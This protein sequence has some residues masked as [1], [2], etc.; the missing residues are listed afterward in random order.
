M[1]AKARIMI[2]GG[3]FAGLS[4]ARTLKTDYDVRLM[5]PGPYFEF[6]PN[7]HELVS[8]RKSALALR[9]PLSRLIGDL[10]HRFVRGEATKIDCEECKVITKNGRSYRYDVLIVAIGGVDNTFNIPGADKFGHRFK[11]VSDCDRIGKHLKNLVE[12]RRQASAVIVGGGLEGVEALGE[13]LRAYRS[14]LNLKL[15]VIDPGQRLL[16]SAPVNIDREIKNRCQPF[17]ISFEHNCTVENISAKSVHLTNGNKIN[18]DLTIWTGGVTGSPLLFDSGLSRKP[19]GWGKV[20]DR[21]LSTRCDNVFIAGDSADSNERFSRQ[22]YHATDMGKIAAHNAMRL[23]EGKSLLNFRPSAKPT[24]I[25]FGD[26]DGFMIAGNR[27]LAG[28]AIG[29]MKEAVYELNM[30][31]FD[32]PTAPSAA[33][34]LVARFGSSTARMISSSF[35]EGKNLLK[36]P[37]VRII[38]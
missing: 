14:A 37:G 29:I 28:P 10:G 32:P 30:A 11:S 38:G 23:I 7:I 8:R 5:A 34:R 12:T 16:G 27:V 22:A 31:L 3:G 17:N 19:G 35:G 20:D 36:L 25:S 9:L 21:L 18:S 26:L 24:L 2:L 1:T 15:T 6:L 4:A 13:I 33:I